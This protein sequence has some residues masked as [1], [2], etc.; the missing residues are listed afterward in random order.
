MRGQLCRDDEDT[1]RSFNQNYKMSVAHTFL[2]VTLSL[3]CVRIISLVGE[4]KV[5][6]IV[7]G[8]QS[9]QVERCLNNIRLI[10]SLGRAV[11]FID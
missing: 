4:L 7:M 8:R 9:P 5:L 1:Q 11:F 6:T 2:L 3:L 10:V